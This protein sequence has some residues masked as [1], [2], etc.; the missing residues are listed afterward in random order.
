MALTLSSAGLVS[1]LLLPGIFLLVNRLMGASYDM[2][3]LLFRLLISE[4]VSLV[5]SL[6]IVLHFRLKARIPLPD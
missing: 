4:A 5:I 2:M 6:F 3:E 1:L